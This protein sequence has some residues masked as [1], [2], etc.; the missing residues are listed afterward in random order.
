MVLCL[1][2]D[3]QKW[4]VLCRLLQRQ[5]EKRGSDRMLWYPQLEGKSPWP[6]FSWI[7]PCFSGCGVGH[8][9]TSFT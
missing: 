4:S 7:D 2:R 6:N 5:R 8:S 3:D 9:I 1:R